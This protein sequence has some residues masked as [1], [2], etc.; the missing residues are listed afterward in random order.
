MSEEGIMEETGQN[1]D[2]SLASYVGVL[3]FSLFYVWNLSMIFWISPSFALEQ[4]GFPQLVPAALFL[5]GTGLGTALFGRRFRLIDSQPKFV[6]F[7]ALAT[8]MACLPMLCTA[9]GI[10]PRSLFV[11]FGLLGF[12]AGFSAVYFFFNWE[13]VGLRTSKG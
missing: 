13:E 7:T 10:I 8:A 1:R 6:G 9:I 2:T 4:V 12:I 11:G 5:L 3:G